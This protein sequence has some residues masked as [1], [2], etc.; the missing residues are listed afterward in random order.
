LRTEAPTAKTPNQRADGGS[1]AGLSN[2]PE[3]L[4]RTAN[5]RLTVKS[6]NYQSAMPKGLLDKF[7]TAKNE[8]SNDE[9]IAWVAVEILSISDRLKTGGAQVD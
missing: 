5:D 6:E 7:S 9:E 3:L 1:S 8:W 2:Y 4:P